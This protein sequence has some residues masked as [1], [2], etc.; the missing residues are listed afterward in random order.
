MLQLTQYSAG[1]YSSHHMKNEWAET[2]VCSPVT[3]PRS[4]QV[5]PA[6]TVETKEGSTS[7]AEFNSVEDNIKDL[8]SI[9]AA[10]VFYN[11]SKGKKSTNIVNRP[12]NCRQTMGTSLQDKHDDCSDTVLHIYSRFLQK[13]W[14]P[15]GPT[16][17]M[18]NSSPFFFLS[19]SSL[20]RHVTTSRPSTLSHVS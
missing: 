12:L 19:L 7:S 2:S 9:W 4:T 8:T 3:F 5:F 11:I 14:F 13:L 20:S 16:H 6:T 1:C 10:C 17:L 15:W 18:R